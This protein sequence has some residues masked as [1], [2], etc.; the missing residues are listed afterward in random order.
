MSKSSRGGLVTLGVLALVVYSCSGRFAAPIE[1]E[2][3]AALVSSQHDVE[4]GDDTFDEDAAR[5]KAEEELSSSSYVDAG[6]SYGCTDDCSGHEAGWRW[7]AENGEQGSNPDS[8]SFEEGGQA[9]DDA[10]EER[11]EEIRSDHES[12]AGE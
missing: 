1:T 12:G 8:P 7:R 5:E 2:S 11:V 9:F 6:A 4:L 3:T 10:V